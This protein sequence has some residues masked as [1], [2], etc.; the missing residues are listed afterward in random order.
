[1]SLWSLRT[2]S[3]SNNLTDLELF[4]RW[5]VTETAILL[6]GQKCR[7]NSPPS[8]Q[9]QMTM[10]DLFCLSGFVACSRSPLHHVLLSLYVLFCPSHPH[11][12]WGIQF[13]SQVPWRPNHRVQYRLQTTLSLV[14]RLSPM[15]IWHISLH[16]T[17]K[18]ALLAETQY[19]RNT[20][21]TLLKYEHLLSADI[22]TNR[23]VNRATNTDQK[24][25]VQIP[26]VLRNHVFNVCNKHQ[27]FPFGHYM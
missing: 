13:N 1:M 27:S 16:L 10:K 19:V 24:L 3:L 9:P 8:Y 26:G 7:V 15:F 17:Q 21:S 25:W 14:L 18:T 6:A 5:D 23:G 12:L 22:K 11:Q 2:M 4:P 20:T